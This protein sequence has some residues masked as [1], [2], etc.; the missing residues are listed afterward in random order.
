MKQ[1]T[2][3]S[4]EMAKKVVLCLCMAVVDFNNILYTGFWAQNLGRVWAKTVS[5]WQ[6]FYLFKE[7]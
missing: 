6:S 3:F 1:A 2:S 5:K 7:R 4:V